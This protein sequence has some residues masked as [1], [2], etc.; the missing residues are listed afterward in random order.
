MRGR[1]GTCH[2]DVEGGG[3]EGVLGQRC[4]GVKVGG[5]CLAHPLLLLA[6]AQAPACRPSAAHG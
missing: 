4:L 6:L 2:A 1:R 5:G 3:D